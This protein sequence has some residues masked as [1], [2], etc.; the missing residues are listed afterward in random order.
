[1]SGT[2][3]SYFHGKITGINADSGEQEGTEDRL[4][5]GYSI[6]Q[7]L[8][9]GREIMVVIPHRQ[10]EGIS[11][12][13]F[14]AKGW[15][16]MSGMKVG[17]LKDPNGGFLEITRCGMVKWFLDT[18]KTN[19][20]LKYLVMIDNDEGVHWHAPM[21]LARHDLP[22]VSGVV[23]GFSPE[24]GMFACFTMPD[25]K[26]QPRFPSHR[27]TKTLPRTGLKEAHQVG[28][29]LLC[30]RKDV[31]QTMWDSGVYPFLLPEESRR[32]SAECG[33]VLKTE[34]II[35]A[36]HARKFGYKSYVDF[37]VEAVHYKTI[38]LSWPRDSFTDSDAIE[39]RVS[40]SDYA[41]VDETQ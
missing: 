4:I 6:E 22:I 15:W 40:D 35:F 16:D 27:D 39:W 20:E 10:N 8:A 30:V 31:L 41:G 7:Q 14:T 32:A 3:D 28:T 2:K 13:F 34:D 9:L 5:P 37:S 21:L 26:G 36:E 25:S 19:P 1:M 18:C 38:P 17:L 33:N 24:R 23:C 29:G 12:S 11:P